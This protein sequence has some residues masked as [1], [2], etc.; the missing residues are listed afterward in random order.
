MSEGQIGLP[1]MNA[2]AFMET[3]SQKPDNQGAQAEGRKFKLTGERVS[4]E[5]E[6]IIERANNGWM[7]FLACCLPA[8]LRCLSTRSAKRTGCACSIRT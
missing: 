3:P 8:S 6:S 7:P 2:Q 5:T 4:R 1:G